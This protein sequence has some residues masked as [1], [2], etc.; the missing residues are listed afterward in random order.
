[1]EKKK[2]GMFRGNHWLDVFLWFWCLGYM[3]LEFYIAVTA[4]MGFA[5]AFGIA[6]FALWVLNEQ[7]RKVKNRR[8]DNL[9]ALRAEVVE[10]E[11]KVRERL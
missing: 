3:L 9:Y 5:L 6:F 10:A 11:R 8:Y 4:H 2:T 1:M 7:T